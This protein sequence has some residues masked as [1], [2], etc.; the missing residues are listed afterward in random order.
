MFNIQGGYKRPQECFQTVFSEYRGGWLYR[1][2]SRTLPTLFDQFS[3]DFQA[4]F[5]RNFKSEILFKNAEHLSGLI[6]GQLF[7]LTVAPLYLNFV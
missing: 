5:S 2:H 1:R 4:D 3:E 7:G 6:G